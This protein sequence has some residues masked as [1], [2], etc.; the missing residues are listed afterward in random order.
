M[1]AGHVEVLPHMIDRVDLGPADR[2][3]T[4]VAASMPFSGHR[5]GVQE[6]ISD[7]DAEAALS[8]SGQARFAGPPA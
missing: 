2:N 5:G 7:R 1:R 3:V 6:C 8:G 4:L